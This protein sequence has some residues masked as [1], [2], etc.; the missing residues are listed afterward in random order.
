MTH[1]YPHA[2]TH[3]HPKAYAK[4]P[5]AALPSLD[6]RS[7]GAAPRSDETER[8]CTRDAVQWTCCSST[9]TTVTPPT[10]GII[11]YTRYHHRTIAIQR[12]ATL[13]LSISCIKGDFCVSRDVTFHWSVRTLPRG[14]GFWGGF[15][16]EIAPLA[17]PRM[18]SVSLSEGSHTHSHIGAH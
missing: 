17:C 18:G 7:P 10:N 13:P 8:E 3:A 16:P 11:N 6:M 1:H 4:Q 12:A 15:C 9:A 14:N 5:N 2:Q